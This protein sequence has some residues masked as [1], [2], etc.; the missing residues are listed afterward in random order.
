MGGTELRMPRAALE[1]GM[2]R[3]CVAEKMPG[4]PDPSHPHPASDG[5]GDGHTWCLARCEDPE[6]QPVAGAEEAVCLLSGF[7]VTLE[8]PQP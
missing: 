6:S 5:A 3:G 1:Q 4:A 2:G 8:Q 7:P